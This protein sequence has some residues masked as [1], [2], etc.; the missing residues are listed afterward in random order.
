MKT[1][2][3]AGLFLLAF[4]EAN[5]KS[6]NT[7]PTIDV[8]AGKTKVD[9]IKTS[10]VTKP[11]S[12]FTIVDKVPEFPGGVDSIAR[13]LNKKIKENVRRVDKS[14]LVVVVLIVEKDGRFTN[15]QAIKHL[16]PESDSLAVK[17]VRQMPKWIPAIRR[18]KPVRCKFSIP[19]RF[20]TLDLNLYP[21]VRKP[22]N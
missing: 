20:G 5:A 15:P 22:D 12:V 10:Q 11:D 1:F 19:V 17:I 6:N 9:T 18:G 3:I 2:L 21:T 8:L 16:N 7:P 14:G 4:M 13:Y